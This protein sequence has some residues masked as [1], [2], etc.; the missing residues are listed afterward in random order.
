MEQKNRSEVMS[1][2]RFP[3]GFRIMRGRQEYVTYID[4]ASLRIWYADD[5]WYFDSHHHSAVEIVVPLRGEVTVSMTDCVYHVQADEV[6]IVPPNTT[7]DLGMQEGSARY[8]LL[9]EPDNIFGMR[10][11]RLIEPMLK[12]PLYISGQ[13]ELQALIRALLLQTVECY[14][15]REPLW[16]SMCYAYLLQMYVRLGQYYIDQGVRRQDDAGRM[17]P[18]IV[19]S[20]RQYIDQNYMR[21]VTLADVAAFAGFSKYYFS[22]VFKQQVGV[23]FSE[24]LRQKRLDV[25]GD[26]LIHTDRPIRDIAEA[27]GFGSIATFNRVFRDARACTPS[28]YR[29]I[30]SDFM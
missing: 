28:R 14:D 24:Y 19:D 13:P 11:M 20:A 4:H 27:C 7:H 1:R 25:A 6:L 18:E 2:S 30:Y 16:N 8:L 21:D 29:E 9:F 17:E 5:P 12:T 10:D 3:D 15:K 26:M 22:R 23:S